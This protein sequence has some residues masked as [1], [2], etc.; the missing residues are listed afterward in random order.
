[1]SKTGA[2]NEIRPPMRESSQ[3]IILKLQVGGIATVSDTPL[4]S[5]KKFLGDLR[6][7]FPLLRSRYSQAG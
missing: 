1:V 7:L 5:E 3:S 4:K 2:L 6:R